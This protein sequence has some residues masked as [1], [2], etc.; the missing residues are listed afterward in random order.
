M[1]SIHPVTMIKQDNFYALGFG[2]GAD[3]ALQAVTRAPQNRQTADGR[4]LPPISPHSD[5]FS[6]LGLIG[7]LSEE[8]MRFAQERLISIP[9]IFR[10]S[11]M[12]FCLSGK[13]DEEIQK[14]SSKMNLAWKS[15]S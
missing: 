8:G 12:I 5:L 3:V 6:S 2:D 7:D 14:N 4:Q 11:K 9:I 15:I 13:N 10:M 1:A